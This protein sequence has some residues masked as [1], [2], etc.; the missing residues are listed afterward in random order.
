MASTV[1]INPSVSPRI[2]Y[3]WW[4]V[5][6][7]AVALTAGPILI[8]GT[9]G[10]FVK[11]LA[12]T[13]GWSRGAISLGFSIVAVMASLAAPVVGVLAD[14]FGPRKVI[15][16][17]ALLFGSGFLSFAFLSASIWHFY[18][19]SLFTALG[20]IGLTT[21]PYATTISRWF[22]RQR[23]LALGFMGVKVFVEGM[24]APPLMTYVITH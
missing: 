5:L 7:T 24:Y 12:E 1:V 13:F 8:T 2:F 11:P 15:L 3:G 18:G 10:I 6:V 21:I 14:R 20:G 19:L 17:A 23:G 16:C 4:M 22:A 9:F